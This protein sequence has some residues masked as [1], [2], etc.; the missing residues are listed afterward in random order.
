MR[1]AALVGIGVAIAALAFSGCVVFKGPIKG[2]QVSEHRVQVKFAICAEAEDSGECYVPAPARG[3]VGDPD[4]DRVLLGFRI[5]DGSKAPR[6]FT[7]RA[8]ASFERSPS[9]TTELNARAPGPERQKWVGYVSPPASEAGP[10]QARFKI[11]FRLPRRPGR[12]FRYRPVAGGYKAE[13][14]ADVVCAPD[15]Y[16]YTDE[17]RTTCISD[18]QG[19]NRTRRNLKIPLD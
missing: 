18:P 1:R 9:Y 17:I 3:S 14:N 10:L 11:R 4:Q 2:K 13:P 8:G 12:A 15:L 16:D 5:P 6:T 19:P 7:S